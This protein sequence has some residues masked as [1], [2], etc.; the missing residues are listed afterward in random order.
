MGLGVDLADVDDVELRSTLERA[1]AL[2]DTYC[3]VPML[4]QK[5]DF[6]GGT[7][8]D[9]EHEWTDDLYDRPRPYRYYPW[10]GPVQSVSSFKIYSTPSVYV[11]IDADEMFINNSGGWI[12]I[13]SL[14][15]T[16]Y[17]LFGAGLITTLL[18]IYHP[19]ARATYTYGWSFPVTQEYLEPTDAWTYRA[20]NQWW[21]TSPAPI[22]YKDGVEQSTGFTIDYDEGTVTFDAALSASNI[23][24][25]SYT[26][27]LPSQISLA[28]GVIAAEDIGQSD[29][30]AKGMSGIDSLTVGEITLRRAANA[31]MRGTAVVPDSIPIKAQNLLAA[32]VKRTVR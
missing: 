26:Y 4:P 18:G 28:T 30:R 21:K 29:L 3:C 6:R 12:E 15:L 27:K 14:K 20:Q 25:A 19:V 17:G 16:Q 5:F 31:G 9:E 22:V 8:T 2:V 7:M 24:T 1:S 13:S 11:E 23:V 32:F 10:A